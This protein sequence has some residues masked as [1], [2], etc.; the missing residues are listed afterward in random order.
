MHETAARARYDLSSLSRDEIWCVAIAQG[1]CQGLET[2]MPEEALLYKPYTHTYGTSSYICNMYFYILLYR[3]WRERDILYP[4]TYKRLSR[5]AA[6]LHTRRQ[7]PHGYSRARGSLLPL[8]LV[9]VRDLRGSSSSSSAAHD[10][11]NIIM[12]HDPRE[13]KSTLRLFNLCLFFINF[14]PLPYLKMHRTIHDGCAMLRHGHNRIHR[15]PS[16]IDRTK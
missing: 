13:T 15:R 8:L 14:S 10:K 12:L 6:T 16:Q 3:V 9:C 5:L 1:D 7:A 2:V 11:D 4:H